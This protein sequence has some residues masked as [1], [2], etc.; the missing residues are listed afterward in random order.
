MGADLLPALT[1]TDVGS[2][3]Y[4]NLPRAINLIN[5]IKIWVA[6]LFWPQFPKNSPLKNKILKVNAGSLFLIRE[7]GKED[8]FCDEGMELKAAKNFS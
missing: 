3:P 7:E 1:A 4:R 2:L 8:N 5:N 6:T